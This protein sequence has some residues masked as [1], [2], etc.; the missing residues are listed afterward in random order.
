M[1]NDKKFACK[2]ITGSNEIFSELTSMK[3]CDQLSDI[4]TI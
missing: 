3:E 4:A 1:M 2:S